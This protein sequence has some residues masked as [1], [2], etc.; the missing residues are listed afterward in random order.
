MTK[1]HARHGF[2]LMLSG[3]MGVLLAFACIPLFGISSAIPAPHWFVASSQPNT[4]L[5]S[6]LFM[7]QAIVVGGVG[8]GL[9][10]LVGFAAFACDLS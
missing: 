10:M 3:F 8:W 5:E 4:Y 6:E 9:P 1:M 7:W 2:S